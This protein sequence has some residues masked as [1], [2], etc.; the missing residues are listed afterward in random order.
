MASSGMMFI[1]SSM[2]I[3]QLVTKANTPTKEHTVIMILSQA[4]FSFEI[5]GITQFRNIFLL[6]TFS[7]QM[8]VLYEGRKKLFVN[9]IYHEVFPLCVVF[10]TFPASEMKSYACYCHISHYIPS[11]NELF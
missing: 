6:A 4:Y 2:E 1:L 5:R 9:L 7:Q 8:K 3:R 11:Q 10:R